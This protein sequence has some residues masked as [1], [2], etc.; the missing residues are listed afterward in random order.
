MFARMPS[1]HPGSLCITNNDSAVTVDYKWL[2]LMCVHI[3]DCV[4]LCIST[5]IEGILAVGEG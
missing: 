2:S 4:Q 3:C 1:E 5:A